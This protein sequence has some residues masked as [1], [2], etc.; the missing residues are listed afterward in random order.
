MKKIILIFHSYLFNYRSIKGWGVVLKKTTVSNLNCQ[1]FGKVTVINSVLKDD[2]VIHSNSNLF[3]TKLYGN[4]KIGSNCTISSSEIGVYTYIAGDSFI[5]EVSIGKFCSIGLG[6]KV[7]L[8]IH[9][10]DF[11]STSPFFYSPNFFSRNKI[12][13]KEYFEEHKKTIIGNDVWIGVNVFINEGVTIGDGVIIGA[14]AVVTKDVPNYSIVGGVPA[15]IIK[16][17]H[18]QDVINTLNDIKWWDNDLQW[19][20]RH[21]EIF[22]KPL[23]NSFYLKDITKKIDL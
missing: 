12:A 2:I 13:E 21:K 17:R 15:K 1:I 19:F 14:G 10:T 8:G 18:P 4:N 3:E 20:E 16:Q 7:G 6:F 23:I 22:Q 9:P 11:V 5:N